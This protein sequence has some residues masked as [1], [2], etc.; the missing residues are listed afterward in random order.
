[1]FQIHTELIVILKLKK[2][3]LRLTLLIEIAILYIWNKVKIFLIE[4]FKRRILPKM[5]VF[6]FVFVSLIILLSFQPGK[7][8]TLAKANNKF[9]FLGVFKH[10]VHHKEE[11]SMKTKPKIDWD[12]QSYKQMNIK[13]K[14]INL[15]PAQLYAKIDK[16]VEECMHNRHSTYRDN[17]IAKHCD[18]Y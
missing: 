7:I 2:K 13:T 11:E 12:T 16:C 15:T 1:M 17:C 9:A 18:I 6:K 14:E 5:L 10:S 8:E 3:N 4:I